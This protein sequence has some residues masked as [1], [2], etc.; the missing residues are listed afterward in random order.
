MLARGSTRI[1]V[2]F[3]LSWGRLPGR[4]GDRLWPVTV[5]GPG[6]AVRIALTSAAVPVTGHRPG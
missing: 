4:A 5:D 1:I 6:V 2:P 3:S